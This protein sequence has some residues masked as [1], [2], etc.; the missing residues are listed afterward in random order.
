MTGQTEAVVNENKMAERIDVIHN[1]V[2]ILL[3][4]E[5]VN[6]HIYIVGRR[7]TCPLTFLTKSRATSVCKIEMSV[8]LSVRLSI[9]IMVS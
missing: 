5:Q 8:S 7:L 9:S 3:T 1:A 6:L 2:E 4:I